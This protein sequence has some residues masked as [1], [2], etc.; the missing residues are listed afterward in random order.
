LLVYDQPDHLTDLHARAT[1]ARDLARDAGG[2]MQAA[3]DLTA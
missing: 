3:T 1:A 2:V